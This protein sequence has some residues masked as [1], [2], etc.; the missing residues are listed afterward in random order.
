MQSIYASR[1]CHMLGWLDKPEHH[2]Q[3]YRWT[4]GPGYETDKSGIS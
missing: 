3:Q 2:A 1:L 4:V